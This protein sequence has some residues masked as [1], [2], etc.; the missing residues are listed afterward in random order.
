L[1]SPK[2]TPDGFDAPGVLGLCLVFGFGAA[3]PF[4]DPPMATAADALGAD[5]ASDGSETTATAFSGTA[6]DGAAA[7]GAAAAAGVA[8]TDAG[9]AAASVVRP[10]DVR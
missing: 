10:R 5:E 2:S 7:V 1:N 3:V 9:V 8:C 4:R 6:T